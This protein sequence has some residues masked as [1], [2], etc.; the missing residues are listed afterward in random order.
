MQ[1]ALSTDFKRCKPTVHHSVWAYAALNVLAVNLS[2][3]NKTARHNR[4]CQILLSV[5]ALQIK[6]LDNHAVTLK[7]AGITIP[8]QMQTLPGEG[9][10][11]LDQAR[12]RGDM[13]VTYTVA[14]PKQLTESQKKCIKE[15]GHAFP[16]RD[17]L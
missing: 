7:S 6:H 10:P 1:V 17:D 16:A 13:H 4:L 5:F 11:L 9:M 8:G 3:I 14:F 2:G 12:K 15:L